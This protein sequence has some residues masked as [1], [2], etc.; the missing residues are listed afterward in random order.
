VLEA[1]DFHGRVDE[2]ANRAGQAIGSVGEEMIE[3]GVGLGMG[4][5]WFG[6]GSVW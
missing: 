4:K 2:Q 1:L 5:V 6:H 3:H